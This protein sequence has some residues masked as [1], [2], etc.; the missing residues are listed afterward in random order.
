MRSGV[1]AACPF[2]RLLF[3]LRD[4][5]VPFADFAAGALLV[6]LGVAAC[7]VLELEWCEFAWLELLRVLFELFCVV[8]CALAANTQQVP[9]A[10]AARKTP[11]RLLLLSKMRI[12]CLCSPCY[13]LSAGTTPARNTVMIRSVGLCRRTLNTTFSP[14]FSLETALR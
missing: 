9:A 6:A 12:T 7:D 4:L 3:F 13:L 1:G 5:E 10:I 14:A 2:T 11:P 8:V